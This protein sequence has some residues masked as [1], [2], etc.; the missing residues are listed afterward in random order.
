MGWIEFMY[1]SGPKTGFLGKMY[2]GLHLNTIGV[3]VVAVL[4]VLSLAAIYLASKN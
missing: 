2:E 4:L 3:L 1:L